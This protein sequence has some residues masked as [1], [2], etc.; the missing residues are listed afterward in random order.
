MKSRRF[1]LY[2][3]INPPIF[4]VLSS[5]PASSSEPMTTDAAELE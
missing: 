5:D 1:L 4:T 3:I 2:F